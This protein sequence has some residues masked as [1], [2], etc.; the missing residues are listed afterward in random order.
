MYRTSLNQLCDLDVITVL[1]DSG[2]GLMPQ[3]SCGLGQFYAIDK[4]GIEDLKA[5]R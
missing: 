3:A 2:F 1:D 5:R 4:Q